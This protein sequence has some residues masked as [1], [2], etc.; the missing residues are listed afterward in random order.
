MIRYLL[1]VLVQ[2]IFQERRTL[3]LDSGSLGPCNYGDS[4]VFAL[5]NLDVYGM[6][7]FFCEKL[8]G[9]KTSGTRYCN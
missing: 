6:K 2:F 4:V 3:F 9:N 5:M 1:A 7:V 8:L